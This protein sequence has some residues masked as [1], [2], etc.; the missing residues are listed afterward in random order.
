MFRKHKTQSS[1]GFDLCSLNGA[2]DKVFKLTRMDTIFDIY[3]HLDQAL[4]EQE[5]R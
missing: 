3:S 1:V 5:T 4:S 2:I